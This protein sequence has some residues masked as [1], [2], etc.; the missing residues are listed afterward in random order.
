MLIRNKAN[1]KCLSKHLLCT[2]YYSRGVHLSALNLDSSKY[3]SG[4]N[5]VIAIRREDQSIWER[6]APL[7]PNHVRKLVHKNGFRVLI[8]PSNRRAFQIPVLFLFYF[9]RDCRMTCTCVCLR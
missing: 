2:T 4:K 3:S 1:L 9:I 7:S 5:K 8:Q 6:R